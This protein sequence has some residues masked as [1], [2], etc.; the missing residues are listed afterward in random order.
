MHL[1]VSNITKS[2]IDLPPKRGNFPPVPDASNF[3]SP[4]CSVELLLLWYFTFLLRSSL[5]V[6]SA[7][8][9]WNIWTCLPAVVLAPLYIAQ[10]LRRYL[11][12]SY[13]YIGI[14]ASSIY[15]NLTSYFYL[16]FIKQILWTVTLHEELIISMNNNVRYYTHMHRQNIYVSFLCLYVSITLRCFNPYVLVVEEWR[17]KCSW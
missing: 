13:G 5:S 8:S 10:S 3:L 2:S 15:H 7:Q 6:F 1:V 4:Y 9:L 11:K 12:S 16:K 17:V 14:S